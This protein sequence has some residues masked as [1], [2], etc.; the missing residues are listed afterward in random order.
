[1]TT[2]D[3][4]QAVWEQ[5]R[6]EVLL[7]VDVVD[8]A[9]TDALTGLLDDET[10]LRAAREAHKLAG[11]IGSLGFVVA[12][13]HARALEDALGRPTPP[14]SSELPQL[15]E[16]AVALRVE[17]T[18]DRGSGVADAATAAP[19][20]TLG[21]LVVD[22]D[23]RRGR[24]L[25]DA[26][27][28]RGLD[29]LLAGDLESARRLSTVGAPDVILLNL[30]IGAD[31]E[32]AMRFLAEVS[33]AHPVMV[34]ANPAER[35]DRVEVARHGGRGFLDPG[36]EP[37]ATVAAAID[38]R[39]RV[40]VRGTRILAVDDD[41][42]I[43]AALKAILGEADLTV[44]TCSDPRQ[45]WERL[46]ETSPDL[47][48]LDFEMP[49][50]SGP[51]LCRAMRNDPIWAGLP[52]IFLT[53]RTDPA[54][55]RTVFAAGADDYLSK[56]FVGPEVVSRIGNRLERVRL[57]QALADTDGLT[58][59]MNRRKSVEAIDVL[60]R[61]GR[62]QGQPVSLGIL[63]VD[64]FKSINDTYGHA[65]GD[66]LLR[67]LGTLMR[68]WFR[69]EDIIARW[70]GDELVVGMYGMSGADGRQRVG[71]FIEAVRGKRFHGGR[72]AVTLSGGVAEYPGD[73]ADVD[74]LYRAA[75]SA[76]YLAKFEGRDRVAPAGRPAGEGATS[77]DVAIVED[78]PVLGLLLQH[79]LQTRGYRTRWIQDGISAAAQLGAATP[80]LMTPLLLLD[81][82]LPGLDGLRVLKTLHDR[83]V[84][85]RT[86]VIMLTARGAEAEVLSA[87]EAGAID[88]VTKPFSIPVLMQ[89]VRRAMER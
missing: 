29:V 24:T 13:E 44:E 88:H 46:E 30:S 2:L 74:E 12:S 47:V 37:L 61:M 50:I 65:G 80:E 1:V 15:A 6:E 42:T 82:D 32:D 39:E 73:G 60:L 3:A 11:S 18:A 21:L 52:V 8:D 77:V 69:G 84:L 41:G 23:A 75:D 5:N 38:L 33:P 35:V 59:L 45:F 83:G 62:R 4:L 85:E 26:A 68:Q 36:L 49:V 28:A 22:D 9:V 63:D 81:W 14:A 40:R 87:L 64:R 58:G 27:E 53:A 7:Q 78:D 10:R 79:A 72:I 34:V 51:E 71:D 76:L 43:L 66:E 86:Q 54:S 19:L 48:V 67:D 31:V 17:L 55:V 89:R 70:G 25:V 16:L 57:Y 20:R 56:P